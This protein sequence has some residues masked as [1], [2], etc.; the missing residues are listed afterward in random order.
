MRERQYADEARR[1]CAQAL[2]VV[3]HRPPGQAALPLVL[4]L[5]LPLLLKRSRPR[6]TL[7][8]VV[9]DV[10]VL[11]GDR[12]VLCQLHIHCLALAGPPE[13]DII[14]A[15]HI[16]KLAAI[17]KQLGKAAPLQPGVVWRDRHGGGAVGLLQKGKGRTEPWGWWVEG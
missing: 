10:G 17:A 12:L 1:S 6:L 14:L 5:V 11:P 9:A 15:N 2:A 3:A 7:F 8:E 13:G 4:P 16:I